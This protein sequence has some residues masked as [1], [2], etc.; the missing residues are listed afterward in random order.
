MA[1]DPGAA[2]LG[3]RSGPILGLRYA[4]RLSGPFNLE[5]SASY[6]P[7]T[8]MVY[9]TTAANEP[10]E[11]IGEADMDLL[12]AEL[13]LKFDVTGPRT[14]YNL[15]PYVLGG[16]GVVSNLSGQSSIESQLHDAVRF[17]FGTR[18]AGHIGA[19][20]EWFALRRLAVRGEVKDT[21]WRLAYPVAI[22]RQDRSLPENEW[23]QNFAFTL[24]LSFRF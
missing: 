8:R 12:L 1:T 14:F 21:F 6:L 24:G 10:F 13:S 11:R 19:G 17:D 5:A 15:L 9:D 20:V 4:Y 18:F 16:I 2:D 22:R 3:P 23:V 7:T